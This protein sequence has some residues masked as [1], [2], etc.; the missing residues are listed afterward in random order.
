MR[1]TRWS[2][3][4]LLLTL[5]SG[6]TA[7]SH[8]PSRPGGDQPPGPP[9][10]ETYRFVDPPAGWPR[11]PKPVAAHLVIPTHPHGRY[12]AVSTERG[13]QVALLVPA[14][15]VERA[16][17]PV[18][19]TAVPERPPAAS[20]QGLRFTA[21]AYV[22][23]LTSRRGSSVALTP[24]GIVVDLRA[25]V[26]RGKDAVAELIGGRWTTLPTTSL[27]DATYQA[28][29]RQAGVVSLVAEPG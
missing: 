12:V 5:I 10:S 21:N 26:R 16:H 15:A 1:R 13:P 24:P 17:A 25:G 7:S 19:V 27:G 3:A 9:P 4:V 28:T 29:I 14:T 23:T 11:T 22:I 2:L 18:S 8:A 20:N 6:C